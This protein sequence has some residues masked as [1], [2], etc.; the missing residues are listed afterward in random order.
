MPRPKRGL[1]LL[2][3]ELWTPNQRGRLA[4]L[5][6]T[7]HPKGPQGPTIHQRLEI[8]G[9][10][11]G[12]G[13]NAD[14]ESARVRRCRGSGGL[15]GGLHNDPESRQWR[16]RGRRR[17]PCCR[18]SNRSRRWRY[19]RRRCDTNNVSLNACGRSARRWIRSRRSLRESSIGP[20][21]TRHT[22]SEKEKAAACAAALTRAGS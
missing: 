15:R 6:Q 21:P 19:C 10:T 8:D 2:R 4:K 16:R 17:R 5:A 11:F 22:V 9:D 18:R 12:L 20:V 14:D 1:H 3:A 13:G 7:V